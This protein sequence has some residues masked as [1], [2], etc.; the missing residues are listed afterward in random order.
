MKLADLDMLPN[1]V[2]HWTSNSIF[3][4]HGAPVLVE[5]MADSENGQIVVG[6]KMVNSPEFPCSE[7]DDSMYARRRVRPTELEVWWPEEGYY[8][9]DGLKIGDGERPPCSR[10]ILLMRRVSRVYKKSCNYR[11]YTH[12]PVEPW[13]VPDRQSFEWEVLSRMNIFSSFGPYVRQ[14]H[15]RPYIE[16][17]RILGAL[18]DETVES[19]ALSR[20]VALARSPKIEDRHIWL[21]VY[22]MSRAVVGMWDTRSGEFFADK[23]G[24]VLRRVLK[25]LPDGVVCRAA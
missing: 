9:L 2:E 19:L 6:I 24:A 14:I 1:D 15:S 11:S 5:G 16:R 13:Y 10:A 4:W 25:K 21:A 20:S 17:D 7:T 8:Q 12:Q 23:G 18:A 3:L 22:G